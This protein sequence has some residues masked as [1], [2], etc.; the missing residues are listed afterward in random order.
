MV[1]AIVCQTHKSEGLQPGTASVLVDIMF[2]KTPMRAL[3]PRGVEVELK[4]GAVVVWP[5]EQMVCFSFP[6]IC[7]LPKFMLSYH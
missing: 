2:A 5:V 7:P 4:K 1:E 3:N 6:L